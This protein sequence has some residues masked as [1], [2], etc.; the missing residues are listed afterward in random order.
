LPTKCRMADLLGC[1]DSPVLKN[2]IF[3]G[4]HFTFHMRFLTRLSIL[5]HHFT[6]VY[7]S[8]SLGLDVCLCTN[9]MSS[10]VECEWTLEAGNWQLQT[11][12]SS[13]L[14]LSYIVESIPFWTCLLYNKAWFLDFIY[15]S[16]IHIINICKWKLYLASDSC[17]FRKTW[18]LI[19]TNSL[20]TLVAS[21]FLQLQSVFLWEDTVPVLTDL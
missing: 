1:F 2:I 20:L 5:R 10:F 3:S 4:P 16:P 13:Q 12:H 15:S 9:I 19:G 18:P 17:T 6:Q 14:H 21:S 11:L 8:Y 7:N